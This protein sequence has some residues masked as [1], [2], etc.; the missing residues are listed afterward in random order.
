FSQFSFREVFRDGWRKSTRA[1]APGLLLWQEG[2]HGSSRACGIGPRSKLLQP[3][4]P[5]HFAFATQPRF[6]CIDGG[7]AR[8]FGQGVMSAITDCEAITPALQGMKERARLS[9]PPVSHAAPAFSAHSGLA[10]LDRQRSRWVCEA[11]PFG[12]HRR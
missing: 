3:P 12:N 6:C 9:T 1:E 5:R 11:S 2:F 7:N 10:A 8:D 4:F